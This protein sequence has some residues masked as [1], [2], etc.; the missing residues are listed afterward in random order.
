MST[1]KKGKGGYWAWLEGETNLFAEGLNGDFAGH[2]GTGAGFDFSAE[3]KR[4]WVFP[5]CSARD[6]WLGPRWVKEEYSVLLPVSSQSHGRSQRKGGEG[7]CT[8]ESG[9]EA[10]GL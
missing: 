5:R 2:L 10:W 9:W 4:Q 1:D 6:Q 8:L 7:F 3:R